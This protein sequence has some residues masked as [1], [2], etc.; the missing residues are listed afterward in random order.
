AEVGAPAAAVGEAVQL[1]EVRQSSSRHLVRRRR[2]LL[3]CC[4]LVG[5]CREHCPVAHLL[6]ALSI[7]E[8]IEESSGLEARREL[9]VTRR[10]RYMVGDVRP[11]AR[12]TQDEQEIHSA[13]HVHFP[14]TVRSLRRQAF[15]NHDGKSL[16]ATTRVALLTYLP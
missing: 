6:L 15:C 2:G 8:L 11:G 5:Q 16:S 10:S 3:R 14:P 1:V 13:Q 4:A 7:V 12:D 9:L